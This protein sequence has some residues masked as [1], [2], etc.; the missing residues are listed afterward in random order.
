MIKVVSVGNWGTADFALESI[1]EV[2]RFLNTL[3]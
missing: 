1:E 2:E 3:A